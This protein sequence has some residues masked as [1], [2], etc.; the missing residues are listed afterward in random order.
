MQ[1]FNFFAG[2]VSRL[3]SI[4]GLM[5]LV[6]GVLGFVVLQVNFKRENIA[7][8]KQVA[9]GFVCLGG[10][11]LGIV[12][13]NIANAF[14]MRGMGLPPEEQF[15]GA[16]MSWYPGMVAGLLFVALIAKIAKLGVAQTLD[17]TVPALVI[18]HCLGRVGCFLVGCCY[19]MEAH[20]RLFGMEF[21]HIPTQLIEAV[22]LLVLFFLLEF[23]VRKNRFAIYLLAYAAF[24]FGIEFLRGDVR[25]ELVG[26]L[27][28]S[29]SQQIAICC[30][31]LGAGILIYQ[32]KKK[33]AA[34]DLPEPQ[35]L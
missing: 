10:L 27:P 19:G 24:R 8:K 16:G 4:Q 17:L 11:V 25:G 22:F 5:G 14:L 6:G 31:A 13:A 30:A 28:L 32:Y 18:F 26:N 33:G 29:P 3:L 9:I 2:L 21:T 34:E 1:F 12:F 15:S 35:T 23:K 7:F 20:F